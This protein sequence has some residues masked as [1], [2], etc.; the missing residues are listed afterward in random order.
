MPARR[1]AADGAQLSLGTEAVP[2]RDPI[3]QE[4]ERQRAERL[5]LIGAATIRRGHLFP[6]GAVGWRRALRGRRWRWRCRR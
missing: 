4:A 5:C 1:G 2:L 3:A 6:S